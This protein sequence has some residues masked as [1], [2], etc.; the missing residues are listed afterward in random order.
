VDA[1]LVVDMQSGMLNGVPKFDLDGVL[2]RIN[3]LTAMIRSRA[4]AVIW[5]QHCST[6]DDAFAPGGPGW[7]LLPGL[8]YQEGDKRIEK[9]LNDPYAGTPLAATLHEIGADRLLV[10]G[11]AT[12]FCVDATVRSSVSNGF[13][14]VAVGDAH[15]VADRPHLTAQAVIQHHNWLWANLIPNRS[16]RVVNTA[17]LLAEAT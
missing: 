9:T 11:W 7:A 13:D 1:L 4:G 17:E 8:D 14:V 6:E 16:I 3:Q 2:G 10:T 5:V 15:T 12:D